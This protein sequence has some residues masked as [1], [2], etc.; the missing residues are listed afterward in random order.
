ML[1]TSQARLGS[2]ARFIKARFEAQLARARSVQNL[3]WLGKAR[4]RYAQARAF[5]SQKRAGNGPEIARNY[6]KIRLKTGQFS[7]Q[8]TKEF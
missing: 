1:L 5:K 4:A 7:R 2:S 3:G 8:T 6:T